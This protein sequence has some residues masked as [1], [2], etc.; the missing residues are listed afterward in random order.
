MHGVQHGTIAAHAEIVI[1]APDCDFPAIIGEVRSRE[2]LCET[3]YVVEVPVG[4]VGV[5]F[6]ELRLIEVVVWEGGIAGCD[7][8]SRS[9]A[10]ADRLPWSACST[11]KEA[12]GSAS[13]RLSLI[14]TG[15]GQCNTPAWGGL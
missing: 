13:V 1:R 15:V 4:L 14:D 10:I 12:C 7:E 11:R 2:V 6:I 3:I 8:T 5:L 9:V